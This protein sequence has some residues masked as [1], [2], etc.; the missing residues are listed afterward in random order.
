MTTIDFAII[1]VCYE[2]GKEFELLVAK[3]NNAE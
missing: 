3:K 2:I 1:D